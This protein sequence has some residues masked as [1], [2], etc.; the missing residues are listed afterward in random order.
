MRLPSTNPRTKS[1]TVTTT[2]GVSK[3]EPAP[4]P[5]G[6]P[7]RSRWSILSFRNI[8]AIYIFVALVIIF[9]VWLG[10]T[11]LNGD[12]LKSMVEN[13]S[14][15][16]LTAIALTIPL[17]AGT[18]NLAIGTQVG[19]GT[20]LS[21][22]LLSSAHESIP[23]VILLTLAA[24]AIVGGACA[25]LIVKVKIDS[26]IATLGVSSVLTAVI[27]W[28]SGDQDILDLGSSF[29]KLGIGELFGVTYPVYVVAILGVVV[30]YVLARTSLGRRLYATGGNIVAAR[31]SGVRTAAMIAIAMVSCGVIAAGAGVLLSSSLATGDPTVGPAYL[32]P[33]FAAAFLGSTQLRAGRYNVWGTLLAVY[34]LATGTTGLQLAGAPTWIPDLFNGVALL[35]AVGLAKAEGA[36]VVDSRFLRL[37]RRRR[38][39][40][41]ATTSE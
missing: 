24:G 35:V 12:T 36:L 3:D 32:L 29:Q 4:S 33:A 39:D 17:A 2:S 23:V 21:A 16:A 11:F 31:L 34:V 1:T 5:P 19:L 15:T 37:T 6:S 20:I 10:A 8:S 30:S 18:F 22:W 13:Q 40:L 41:D 28:I 14:I 9:S 25:L 27:S 26:F 38:G 7:H